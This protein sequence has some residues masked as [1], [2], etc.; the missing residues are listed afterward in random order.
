VVELDAASDV[1]LDE[2]SDVTVD[3]SSNVQVDERSSVNADEAS[4]VRPAPILP[5]TRR[6]TS[7]G[8]ASEMRAKRARARRRPTEPP[9]SEKG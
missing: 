1:R 6:R 7:P 4:D 8:P 9:P 3:D 5:G 2:G